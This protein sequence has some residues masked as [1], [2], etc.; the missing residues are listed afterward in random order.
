MGE[1]VKLCG[2]TFVKLVIRNQVL[3]FQ[4]QVGDLIPGSWIVSWNT[5]HFDGVEKR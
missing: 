2:S 4:F 5:A 1:G 3:K